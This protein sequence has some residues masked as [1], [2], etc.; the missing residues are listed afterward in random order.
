VS[1]HQYKGH[2]ITLIASQ[3]GYMW[4]CRYVV[5]RSGKTEFDGFP[6]SHPPTP[7]APR[8]AVSTG[9][10]TY[11]SREGAESAALAKAKALI[12][13]A[14]LDKDSLASGY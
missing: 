5:L 3:E 14:S 8:R 4:A 2:T 7:G 6:D 13:Q 11:E 9:G 12:D 10:N 1:D